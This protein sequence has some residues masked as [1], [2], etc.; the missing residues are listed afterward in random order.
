MAKTNL[1]KNRSIDKKIKKLSDAS[2][3][4]CGE[5]NV[6]VLDVHRIKPGEDGGKYSEFNSI[7]LCANCH[8]KVHSKEI[9]ITGKYKS[10]NGFVFSFIDESGKETIKPA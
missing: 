1:L 4:I 10:T 5:S 6:S 9:K 2:C 8:R 3:R 7:T